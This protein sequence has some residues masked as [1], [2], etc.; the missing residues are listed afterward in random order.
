MKRRFYK[1]DKGRANY[2]MEQMDILY[3]PTVYKYL[4]MPCGPCLYAILQADYILLICRPTRRAYPDACLSMDGRR[5]ERPPYGS[6]GAKK[7][8]P[9]KYLWPLI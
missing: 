5:V 2:S 7:M 1:L 3:L 6:D 9:T 4:Y 8:G